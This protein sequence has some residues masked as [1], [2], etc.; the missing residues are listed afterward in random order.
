MKALNKITTALTENPNQ[1]ALM[2]R[3]A[4]RLKASALPI[5][6]MVRQCFDSLNIYGKEPEQVEN[7]ILMF[8][9][10][11]QEYEI[12]EIKRAFVDWVKSNAEMPTPAGIIEIIQS[13]RPK[14]PI[15]YD[16]S[17]PEEYEA[18][19]E[20]KRNPR[21]VSWYGKNWKQFTEGDKKDLSAHLVSLGPLKANDYR[22]YL[23]K[24]CEAPNGLFNALGVS[25]SEGVR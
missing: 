6:Q 22:L 4:E 23:Q 25:I 24:Y 20:R 15:K 18:A 10:A 12:I 14:A 19:A 16:H 5:S 17:T 9:H 13:Y 7:M 1:V 3:Q 21:P 11:L 8:I 2:Q